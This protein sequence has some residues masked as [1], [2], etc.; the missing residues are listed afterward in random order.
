MQTKKSFY[1]RGFTLVELMVTLAL[2]AI[3]MGLAVPA[4]TALIERTRITSA[5]M[6]IRTALALARSEAVKRSV[7]V[8]LCHA[9]FP[10]AC[11]GSAAV[12]TKTW[13]SQV[14]LFVDTNDNRQYD[15]SETLIRQLALNTA[16]EL[17]WNRGDGLKF[18]PTGTVAW[19]SN[20]TFKLKLASGRE[21]HLVLNSMGRVR[22]YE[23]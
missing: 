14:L 8:R 23:P 18:M 1:H 9:A 16:V 20:G 10:P 3:I 2:V 15:S 17:S 4:F 22:S 5:A 11:A 6:D 19:G 21:M 13:S 7:P 12:G